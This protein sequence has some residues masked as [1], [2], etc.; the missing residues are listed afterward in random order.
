MFATATMRTLL[1]ATTLVAVAFWSMPAQA[2][3]NGPE[4]PPSWWN[5]PNEAG[6]TVKAGW[7]FDDGDS[8]DLDQRPDWCDEA[9][10]SVTGGNTVP[11]DTGGSHGRVYGIPT[12]SHGKTG[13][14]W[15]HVDNQYSSALVKELW[16][17]YDI[18]RSGHAD[19][20]CSVD[21]E[22]PDGAPDP[23]VTNHKY[24]RLP[25][26][27]GGGWKRYTIRKWITPQPASEWIKF[28]L[29]TPA[30]YASSV[31]I[32]NVWIGAHCDLQ[33]D[34]NHCEGYD[35]N[36]EYVPP[37]SPEPTF[38][39][40]PSWYGGTGWSSYGGYPPEWMASVTDHLG[41]VGIPAGPPVSG[42][43]EITIDDQF[44][45]N[46][47]RPIYYKY[48]KH[49]LG[50][51]ITSEELF[52]PGTIIENRSEIVEDLGEGWECVEVFL[53]AT[54]R[55]D[56]WTVHFM[57]STTGAG[58]VAIDN[59]ILSAGMA[60]TPMHERVLI[61]PSERRP[62]TP[63][64]E[65]PGGPVNAVWS[66]DFDAYVLG[67]DVHGQGGWK[68]WGNDPA[69]GALVS[70][71]QARSNPHSVDVAGGTD[72]VHE[73]PD[74]N[75]GRWEFTAWQYIPSDFVGGGGPTPGSFFVLMN[76]YSDGG[77]WEEQHW[78]VQYN[79]DSNDGMLKVYY[80]DGLNTVDVPYIPDQWVEINI[81]IDLDI[82]ACTISYDGMFLAEYS[83]TGGAT[84][85]GGGALDIAAVDLYANGSTSIYY[86]D[87]SLAPARP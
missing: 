15:F 29:M 26:D 52:P 65:P 6:T 82:D 28:T 19:G 43:I 81:V 45:P 22:A 16:V 34:K 73:Y 20:T 39:C 87:V 78:S 55:P 10:S 71:V 77:P 68:G 31:M 62:F 32:D 24:Q 17:Q 47:A 50:G 76:T 38:R 83:W 40:A 21:P 27:L 86:D 85:I 14:L 69:L 33:G 75:S 57:M 48:N 54:P 53:D 74:R 79:F 36:D 4:Q 59:L 5:N 3:E 84:G 51:P 7:N 80:G 46:E 72:L 35:F 1:T 11:I 42:D 41:V 49:V 23:T 66:E 2:D 8:P 64:P 63:L 56:W 67:S 25:R 13:L 18:Y 70:D 44:D 58:P 30:G 9:P 37:D 12:N 60:R 61:A